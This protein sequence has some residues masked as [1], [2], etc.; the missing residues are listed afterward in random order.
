MYLPTTF[1]QIL[2]FMLMA[3]MAPDTPPGAKTKLKQHVLLRMAELVVKGGRW[4]CEFWLAGWPARLVG[5][6]VDWWFCLSARRD[7]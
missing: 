3:H 6:L 5:W 1:W 4:A 7:G 2:K